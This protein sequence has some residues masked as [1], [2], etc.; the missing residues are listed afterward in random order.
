M[1][2]VQRTLSVL[3][4]LAIMLSGCSK[5]DDIAATTVI[6]EQ[7]TEETGMELTQKNYAAEK[8]YVKTLG[9]T[10][11]EEGILWLALSASGV[12]FTMNGTSASFTVVSDSMY[13]TEE[14]QPRIAAYV[15]GERVVDRCLDAEETVIDI[16]SEEEA[17]EHT[18]TIIK[19]SEAAESTCGIKNISVTSV[20]DIAPTAEKEL[21]IEFIGDSIT[22]GYGVDDE[23]KEHHFSTHTEDA[24]KAYAYKTAKLLDADYSLV[25]YSG[26]GIVS[27]YTT[28]GKK[29]AAQQVPAMYTQFAR[30]YGNYNGFCVSSV[31]WDFAEFV[32]DVIVINLGTNDASYTG[33]D[34]TLRAEYSEAYTEFLKKVRKNNPDA[35]IICALGVMGDDL[36]PSVE[37]AVNAFV[38]ESG[39]AKVSAFRLTPQDGST[40]FAADWHPTAV[41]HDRAAEE[42]TAEIK[43]ILG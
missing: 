3:S 32:P 31:S 9:R 37:S 7:T 36:Y 28:Q 1:T 6:K 23:V 26:H 2:L 24:T 42:L 15:D 12:E 11:N 41:T 43:R 4:A 18:I 10:H 14:K 16:F 8:Q 20:G 35:Y 19:L 22:C 13:A 29:V 30:S 39:D 27:G 25:S 17:K 21:K 34:E 33:S 38:E 40:G 5:P